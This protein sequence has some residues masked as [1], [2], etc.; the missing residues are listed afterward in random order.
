MALARLLIGQDDSLKCVD[1]SSGTSVIGG[2]MHGKWQD[3]SLKFI[4]ENSRRV[5]V[6]RLVSGQ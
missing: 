6:A 3:G 5:P 4:G 2:K 1:E